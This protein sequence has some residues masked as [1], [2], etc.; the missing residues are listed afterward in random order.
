[1]RRVTS[2]PTL[3]GVQRTEGKETQV[4][5]LAYKRPRE[6][7]QKK[8][9]RDTLTLSHAQEGKFRGKERKRYL[10]LTHT[11]SLTQVQ[12]VQKKK[13]N[14]QFRYKRI[15][16]NRSSEEGRKEEIHSHSVTHKRIHSVTEKGAHHQ[17]PR[18]I[19]KEGRETQSHP[20]WLTHSL[21]YNQSVQM[22]KKKKNNNNNNN[23][24]SD[25]RD[26]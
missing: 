2:P 18:R 26:H 24:H 8:E 12:P 1:M 17:L 3:E 19:A 10:N 14:T 20:H 7:V 11:D 25:T 5:S 21:R 4:H 15:R 13:N 9:G 6:P 22:K 23:T 16:E